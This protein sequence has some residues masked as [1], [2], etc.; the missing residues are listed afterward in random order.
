MTAILKSVSKR[1]ACANV[2]VF[3]CL[4]VRVGG[5]GVEC[6]CRGTFICYLLLCLFKN[7]LEPTAETSIH[8]CHKSEG[9]EGGSQIMG[10]NI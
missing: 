3:V 9:G 4:Y 8:I 10:F 6:C 2:D 7:A 1:G 5:G